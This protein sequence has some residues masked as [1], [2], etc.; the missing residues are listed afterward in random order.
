[1]QTPAHSRK[2]GKLLTETRFY[3]D[4]LAAFGAPARDHGAA[5]LGL[6]AGAK[7]VRL[8]TVTPVGLERALGHEKSLLLRITIASGKQKV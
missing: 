3:G 8:R 5:A 7:S 1:L 6:H 4:P 2:E